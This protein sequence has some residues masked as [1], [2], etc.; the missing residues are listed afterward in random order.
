M[1]SLADLHLD[2]VTFG[3]SFKDML[4]EARFFN[5]MTFTMGISHFNC[6]IPED[7]QEAL[8]QCIY[9]WTDLNSSSL[10]GGMSDVSLQSMFQNLKNKSQLVNLSLVGMCI[11]D[12]TPNAM[13]R[14]LDALPDLEEL[15]LWGNKISAAGL[16]RLATCLRKRP[17][18]LKKLDVTGNPG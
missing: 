6:N 2:Q 15:N 8:I 11:S 9:H 14:L 10:M 16:E 13:L 4:L 17:Q 5:L 7:I 3:R 1:S 12:N 18:V